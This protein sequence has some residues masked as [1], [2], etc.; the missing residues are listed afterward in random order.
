MAD[1]AGKG[2]MLVVALYRRFHSNSEG[3]R[4]LIRLLN[5]TVRSYL[6]CWFT[7]SSSLNQPCDP[8]HNLQ[9]LLCGCRHEEQLQASVCEEACT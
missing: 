8:L 9:M 3:K 5:A 2:S 7:A 1:V 4:A 6:L